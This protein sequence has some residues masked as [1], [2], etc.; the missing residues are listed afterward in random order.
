MHRFTR[1]IFLLPPPPFASGV[2]CVDRA[3]RRVAVSVRAPSVGQSWRY[4]KVAGLSGRLLDNQ[5]RSGRRGGQHRAYRFAQRSG[6]GRA[7]EILGSTLV[8]RLRRSRQSGWSSAERGSAAMGQGADRSALVGG[9]AVRDPDSLWPTEL[10]PGWSGRFYTKYTTP[11]HETGLAVGSDDDRSRSGR[12]SASR[13]AASR[14]CAS[15]T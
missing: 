13:R 2:R 15:P 11:T 8:V 3:P 7:Q 6:R 1:P 14:R 10:R 9:A 4:A 5:D 12:R